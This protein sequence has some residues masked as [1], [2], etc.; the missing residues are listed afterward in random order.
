MRKLLSYANL[1]NWKIENLYL[2]IVLLISGVL[3]FVNLG[4]SDFQGDE[5]KALFL[6]PSDTTITDFLL[7]QRKGPVQFLITYLIKLIDPYYLNQFLVRLPFA[8]AGFF[9]VWV[10]YRLLNKYFTPKISFYASLFMATNG[11]FVAFARIAQYQSVVILFAI[12]TLYLLT[13]SIETPKSTSRTKYFV[14]AF[15]S[16]AISI[17]AHYDGIFIFP[18]VLA[19]C[20][21]WLMVVRQAN[22]PIFRTLFLAG[23]LYLLLLLIFYLPF[24]YSITQDTLGYWE[25]RLSGDVSSKMSSSY[26]L[27]TVYQPIYVVH[28]Y[29]GLFLAGVIA[30]IIF[31]VS[32]LLPRFRRIKNLLSDSKVVTDFK[33]IFLVLFWFM[34]TFAFWEF[35]V[36]IPGTHIYNYLL[37]TFVFMGIGLFFIENIWVYLISKHLKFL[38]IG[39]KDLFILIFF[40]FLSLQSYYIFVDNTQEYPW[41]QEKFLFWTLPQPTPTFHLSMFGFPYY[42]DWEGISKFISNYP[43]VTAYSTNERESISRYHIKLPKDTTRAGFFVFI[44]NPQSFT[45]QILNEKALYWANNNAPVYTLSR[46]G[47]ELVN[48]YLMP[49]GTL[50]E[51]EKLDE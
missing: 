46:G 11:F 35:L 49:T 51:L 28:F 14:L 44:R 27:F 37:P 25:G 41:E 21:K 19:L 3:R 45:N 5:I 7:S 9:S 13:L 8:L 50:A 18:L 48:I 2:L 33:T 22:Q 1:K 24:V 23:S 17:L 30:F 10:F 34:L 15:V 38:K 39:P 36:S 47:N 16:W 12:L 20:I 42:R 32:S 40:T 4:Y 26:Y 29:L 43:E 31:V 6:I